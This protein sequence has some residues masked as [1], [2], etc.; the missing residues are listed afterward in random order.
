M[1]KIYTDGSG[2]NKRKIGA[3][4]FLIH[5]DK[6]EII[7][8]SSDF[9]ENTTTNRMEMMGVLE[10]LRY[11]NSIDF[12]GDIEIISDSQYVIYSITKKWNKEKN[13]DLWKELSY[14]HKLFKSRN[15]NIV[16]NWIKGHNGQIYNEMVDQMAG[17]KL[18]ELKNKLEIE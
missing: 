16:Y 10:A 11:L 2:I 4:A 6:N 18:K 13:V 12:V 5:N 1:Y 14:N 9:V 15:N 3:Y 8:T 17:Q 7:Y